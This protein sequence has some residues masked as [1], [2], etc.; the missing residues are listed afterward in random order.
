VFLYE[1]EGEWFHVACK[2][3]YTDEECF[4]VINNA[5]T[6]VAISMV[7]RAQLVQQCKYN[8]VRVLRATLYMS[9]NVS[10]VTSC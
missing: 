9:V 4:G 6:L 1:S 3:N 10:R 7:T 5:N 8:I 2:V